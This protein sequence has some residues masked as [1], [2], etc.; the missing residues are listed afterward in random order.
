MKAIIAIFTFITLTT[1]TSLARNWNRIE[2]PGA[3]CGDGF[4]YSVFV[5][6]KANSKNLLVEFMGGGACWDFSTCYGVDLNGINFKTWMHP[7]PE[8]PFFSYMTSDMMF[9]DDHPFNDDS[10]IYL[11]YCTGDVFSADH[12]A[13]YSGVSAYHVGFRNVIATFQYLAQRN[14]LNFGSVDRLTV[15]GASAGAIGAMVHLKT[16]EPYFSRAKK[17]GIIDSAGLHFGPTFWNKFTAQ[18]V[19]DF[20]KAFAHAGLILNPNDGF[21]A[22]YMGPVL[23]NLRQWNIGIMQSTR[24][25]VMSTAFGEITPEDHRRLVLS[26]RGIVAVARNYP[27]TSV[28]I[29]DTG[30]HTFMLLRSTAQLESMAKSSAIAFVKQVVQK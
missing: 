11:P 23:A 12:V 3:V 30:Q 4:P 2:I 25:G 8:V 20:S 5:N 9:W 22:Q 16:I 26:N 13:N 1:Q 29:N 14:I 17:I 10:A 6:K 28:W 15:Y 7:M 27:N 18:L 21:V 24:D 19:G